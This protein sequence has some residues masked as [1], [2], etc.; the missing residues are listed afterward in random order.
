MS[1]KVGLNRQIA[2]RIMIGQFCALSKIIM[3]AVMPLYLFYSFPSSPRE[4]VCRLRD[5]QH[6]LLSI[7]G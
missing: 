2:A 6:L 7:G 5:L 1:W 3:S 4:I